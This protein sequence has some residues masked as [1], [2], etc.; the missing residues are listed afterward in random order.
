MLWTRITLMRIRIRLTSLMRIRIWFQI[1]ASKK[2]FKPVK[3]CSN[4]LKFHTFWL[5]ICK[6]IRIFAHPDADPDPQHWFLLTSFYYLGRLGIC[7]WLIVPILRYLVESL[8]KCYLLSK[9]VPKNL[10][11]YSKETTP[12]N[13]IFGGYMRQVISFFYICFISTLRPL[14]WLVILLCLSEC[15][16]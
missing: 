4:S 16:C 13:Q 5:V 15:F 12:F 2:M 7:M 11:N 8:Q 6:M 14:N 10:D 1:L 3:K 9:Q